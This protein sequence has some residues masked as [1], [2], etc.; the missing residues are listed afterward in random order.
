M[1]KAFVFLGNDGEIKEPQKHIVKSLKGSAKVKY[2]DTDG[3]KLTDDNDI[4][5]LVR[6]IKDVQEAEAELRF[7]QQEFQNNRCN[8]YDSDSDSHKGNN[9][10]GDDRDPERGNGLKISCRMHD[11]TTKTRKER[12]MT[13]LDQR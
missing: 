8:D 12:I 5:D 2:N 13:K 9:K 7:K 11:G 10:K 6:E 1:N 3:K 4:L